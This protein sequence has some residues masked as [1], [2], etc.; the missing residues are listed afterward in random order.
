MPSEQ[1]P[2]IPILVELRERIE[3]IETSFANVDQWF[4]QLDEPPGDDCHI[5]EDGTWTD[6]HTQAVEQAIERAGRLALDD[7]ATP[8]IRWLRSVPSEGR[9]DADALPDPDSPSFVADVLAEIDRSVAELGHREPHEPQERK[10]GTANMRMFDELSKNADAAGW[11]SGQWARFLEC[12]RSTVVGTK[13]WKSLERVR[14]DAKAQRMK[15]RRRKPK[16]SDLR[17][18]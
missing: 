11:S 13:A 9:K 1:H 3:A 15:D 12:S 6:S 18:T 4:D 2:L 10:R 14:L 16:A 17:D 8:I 5:I 7:K